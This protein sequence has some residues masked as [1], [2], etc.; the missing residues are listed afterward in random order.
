MYRISHSF[1]K[2][3]VVVQ[4]AHYKSSNMPRLE[5]AIKIYASL[6]RIESLRADVMKK[7]IS[8]LLHPYPKVRTVSSYLRGFFVGLSVY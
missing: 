3:F 6:S 2:L 1:R 7:L 4:K 8:M 5:A